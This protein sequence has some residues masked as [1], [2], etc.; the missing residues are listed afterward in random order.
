MLFSETIEWALAV[1]L[2]SPRQLSD[3]DPL[4]FVALPRIAIFVGCL[5]LPNS[6]I[7]PNRLNS[8]FVYHNSWFYHFDRGVILNL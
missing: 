4:L 2:I 5:L 3:R 1:G 8:G 6:P 7:G